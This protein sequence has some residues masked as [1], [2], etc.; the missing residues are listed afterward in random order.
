V[1]SELAA[2]HDSLAFTDI[3]PDKG[4]NRTKTGKKQ[5]E[6]SGRI[7]VASLDM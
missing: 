4:N 5:K 7:K 6:V 3:Q 1:A 2:Q